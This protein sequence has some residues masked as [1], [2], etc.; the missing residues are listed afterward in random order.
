MTSAVLPRYC[1][2]PNPITYL[3]FA[4]MTGTEETTSLTGKLLIA[5]PGMGDARFDK[6]VVFLC[7]HSP[8]G[9]MGL[10]INKPAPDLDFNNLLMQL[11]IRPREGHPHAPLFF[12]GPVET[13]RGFVLHSGEY[14]GE[15]GT[16]EVDDSFA[17]TATKNILEDIAAGQGPQKTL[18]S[19]GYSGWGPGQLESELQQNAWLTCDADQQI[20]FAPDHSAKWQA[21][22][23]KLGINP[24]ML[25]AEGGRA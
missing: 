2:L 19:L 11:D 16:L 9:T 5:M 23:A 24:L 18:T 14:R 13:G 6:A 10:I 21:A 25:S 1:P 4:P 3:H 20:V 22:L 15:D 12:G 7:L 8:E 17:M